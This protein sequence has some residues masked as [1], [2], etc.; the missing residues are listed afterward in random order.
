MVL[1][2]LGKR[3][4]VILQDLIFGEDLKMIKHELDLPSNSKFTKVI[5][6]L[7]HSSMRNKI[8]KKISKITTDN[9]ERIGNELKG[10][11]N[12]VHIK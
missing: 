9:F 4:K 11:V 1:L 8:I 5:V 2:Y 7:Y 6:S 12:A 3:K 10:K